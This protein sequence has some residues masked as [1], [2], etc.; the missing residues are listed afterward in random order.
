MNNVIDAYKVSEVENLE[1]RNCIIN[2]SLIVPVYN[3]FEAIDY[4]VAEI[5]SALSNV[6]KVEIEIVFI[7]DGS[8]DNTLG[9]ILSLPR[10]KFMLT[11][12]DLSRNFGKEA[13]I[14]AGLQVAKGNVVIP[15]DVDLQDPP[16]LIPIMLAKWREGYDIV[17]AKRSNRDT[18]TWMKRKFA[19]WF[20]S[21]HN[22]ISDLKL[23]SN[24]GDYRL[25]DRKIVDILNQ[26][27]ETNRFMKGLYAWAGFTPAIIEYTRM[28]RSA[29]DSKFNGW[30]LWNLGIEAITSF[31]TAPLRIWT[32]LG[33]MVAACSIIFAVIIAL[34]VIIYGVEVSGYASLIVAV[35]MIGG[36]QLIGIGILGEYLG[37]VY[38]ESKRRPIYVIKDTYRI[39]KNMK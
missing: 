1:R 39:E 3:E 24:V 21:V 2:I 17:L 32:Y 13:A 5:E 11:V 6:E 38:M 37:R 29:G 33:L 18:D 16:A 10:K 4:F 28:K 7:N 9:K 26:L 31:S 22:I 14:S 20:Y 8:K 27:P 25:L 34:R 36:I 30:R 23:H 12:I 35:T 15:I 19:E